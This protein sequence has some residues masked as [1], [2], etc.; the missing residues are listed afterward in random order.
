MSQEMMGVMQPVIWLFF[1]W[2][3]TALISGSNHFWLPDV[4]F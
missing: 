3:V 1:L 2:H 4:Y